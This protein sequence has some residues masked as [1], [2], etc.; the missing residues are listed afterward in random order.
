MRN[1]KEKYDEYQNLIDDNKIDSI[2]DNIC[3]HI[4]GIF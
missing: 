3:L 4:K 1:S 2:C